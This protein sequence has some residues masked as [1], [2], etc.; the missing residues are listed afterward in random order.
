MQAFWFSPDDHKLGHDD[1][2]KVRVGTTHTIKGPPILCKHGLHASVR[3]IDAL[4]YAPGSTLYLVDISGRVLKDEDKIVGTK[5]RYLKRF[6]A[7]KLLR[8]FTRKQALINI[9]KIKPY[10]DQYDL[11]VKYLTT[12]KKS[13][14]SAARSAAESAAR[15]AANDML[16]DMVREATGWNI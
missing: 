13:L 9:E 8:A 11:I 2:R 1:S 10:T 6:D 15:S 3:L 7:E 14:Q 16:L 5:R 12:G 4:R